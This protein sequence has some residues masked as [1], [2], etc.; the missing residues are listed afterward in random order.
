[1]IRLTNKKSQSPNRAHSRSNPN[2]TPAAGSTHENKVTFA[3]SQT[4]TQ[5]HKISK[6]Q[7]RFESHRIAIIT[8]IAY[9]LTLMQIFLHFTNMFQKNIFL[10]FIHVYAYVDIAR[11]A[12][13]VFQKNNFIFLSTSAY[14]LACNTH[15]YR[16][17][18]YSFV[19]FFFFVEI[20]SVVY[21][22][23]A[24]YEYI[25]DLINRII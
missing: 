1:M 24:R 8:I 12:K 23:T 13:A 6:I 14:F 7:L 9:H 3:S 5:S 25:S 18:R 16:Y 21:Y 4:F 22:K 17:I 2:K 20:F 10:L 11:L 19:F 15:E